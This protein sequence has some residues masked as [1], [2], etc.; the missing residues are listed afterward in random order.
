MN[1][2]HRLGSYSIAFHDEA[3]VFSDMPSS[4]YLVTD[5]KIAGLEFKLPAV[6]TLAV[7]EG[8]TSKSLAVYSEIANWLADNQALRSSTLVALGGGVVGDVAGFAAATYMRGIKLLMIPTTLLAMVD[9]SIGGKVGIDL[10]QGKNLLGAFMPPGEVRICP[11]LLTTL[12]DREIRNGLAEVLKYGFIMEPSLFEWVRQLPNIP[13]ENWGDGIKL[14]L[15]CKR[16]IVEADEFELNGIRATLNF[17]HTIG[18]AI[19]AEVGF[20]TMLHGEAISIGMNVESKLG[21]MVG[22]SEEGTQVFVEAQLKNVG[23]PVS[24]SV[25]T[26]PDSLISRM[27]LDKK[28]ELGSLSFALLKKIG[29]CAQVKN[30]DH[31]AVRNSIKEIAKLRI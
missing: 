22:I 27:K 10:P 5:K 7:P 30:V 13:R 6:P 19:E 8:E 25:L 4:V 24:H 15:E 28:N 2:K 12:E 1:V 17:G 23:L 29:E 21:E 31:D 20:G 11:S 16:Q 18:H 3:S 14:C 26:D 9:S